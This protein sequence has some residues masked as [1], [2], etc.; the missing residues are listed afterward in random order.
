MTLSG[1]QIY[2]LYH[3]AGK[4]LNI[5]VNPGVVGTV[6]VRLIGAVN[7]NASAWANGALLSACLNGGAVAT[8][9]AGTASTTGTMEVGKGTANANLQGSIRNVKFYNVRLTDAELIAMTT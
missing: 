6:N 3:P 1:G 5:F 9:V 7:K 4:I 8:S 2:P